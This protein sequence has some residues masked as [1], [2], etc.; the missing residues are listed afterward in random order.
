MKILEMMTAV[1]LTGYGGETR[2]LLAGEFPFAAIRNT[3]LAFLA[4]NPV[5]RF[6]LIP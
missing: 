3:R 4:K 2:P 5:G 1:V 6:V